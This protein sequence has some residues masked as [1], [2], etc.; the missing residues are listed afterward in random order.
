MQSLAPAIQ[1]LNSGFPV[2]TVLIRHELESLLSNSICKAVISVNLPF[3][4]FEMHG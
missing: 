4:R 1:A 3:S 2:R